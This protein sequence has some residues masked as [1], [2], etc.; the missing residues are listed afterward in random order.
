M[1]RSYR[2]GAHTSAAGGVHRAAEE[3]VAIG[4]NTVQV[5]TRSP[6]MW[7]GTPPSAES[8]ERLA[9]L[10][11]EHDLHPLAVHGC[12]LTNLA[13]ASAEVQQRSRA[14][15][16]LELENAR[17]IGADYLVIHP[18]SAKGQS[19]QRAIAVFAAAVAEV[20]RGFE[21][22]SLRLLLENTAGGGHT[23]GVSFPELAALGEAV[24]ALCDARLGFCIDTAHSFE[25]GY[26]IAS[27][28]GLLETVR[29]LHEC[30]GMENVHLL[31]A[32]DS[33]TEF[34][35]HHDR[36]ESIGDGHIGADAFAR[37]LRHPQLRTKPFILETPFIDGSHRGERPA[38]VGTGG[39][40]VARLV[41]APA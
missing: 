39:P 3:A 22:G 4:C 23:L 20:Q 25:A 17:S 37:I 18:G 29:S 31:H 11:G 12:Y 14:S 36:H 9:A 13:A 38:A 6:R 32:N 26:D 16:R 19:R 41:V 15:F 28:Q 33:K 8:I 24:A 30:L 10:R 27:E 5:F 35:S 1:Q 34:G 2:I 40:A 21:W 7:R